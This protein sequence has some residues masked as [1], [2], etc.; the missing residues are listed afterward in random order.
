MKQIFTR[1][2]LPFAQHGLFRTP[3]DQSDR[4]SIAVYRVC[5]VKDETVS[6][7]QSCVSNSKKAHSLIRNLILTRGQGTVR[8]CHAQ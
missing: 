2:I 4:Q 5:L 6:F 8:C 7:G 3:S 1:S